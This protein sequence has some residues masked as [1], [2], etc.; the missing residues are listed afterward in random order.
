[1]IDKF[2]EGWM[3]AVAELNAVPDNRKKSAKYLAELNALAVEDAEGMIDNVYLTSHG[4]NLNFFGLNSAYKGQ[5]GSDLYEKMSRKF[6]EIG[7]A[8]KLAPAWR[9]VAYTGAIQAANAKLQ[10]PNYAAEKSKTF[11]RP[12]PAEA[13]APA[14]A[15][16][17]ASINFASGQY[18]LSENAKTIIDLQFSEIAKS[19][20]NSRVRVEGNTDSDG[21]RAMNLDLSKKR[22]QSVANY[23]ASQYSMDPNRFIIIG[24]GPDKPVPGCESNATPAC[25]AQNRRTEFQLI[26]G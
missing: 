20:A 5:K 2:Y 26:G 24:N 9:S 13:T 6:V 18:N 1:M 7:D 10:G 19:F 17:P 22:A 3:K 25:K 16:K 12:T 14:I 21:G 8:E 15:S 23:L 11:T 4:D